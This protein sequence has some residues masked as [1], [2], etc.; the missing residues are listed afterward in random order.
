M[1]DASAILRT[2]RKFDQ[3]IAGVF[4]DDLRELAFNYLGFGDALAEGQGATHRARVEF[5]IG[6][7]VRFRQR[8]VAADDFRCIVEGKFRAILEAVLDC[9]GDQPFIHGQNDHLVV[10]Q[11]FIFDSPAE[12]AME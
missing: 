7:E 5:Q 8:L 1:N 11:Q 3:V 4:I 10:G 6:G 12:A 9:V 2:G